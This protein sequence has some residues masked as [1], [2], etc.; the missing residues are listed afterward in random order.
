MF[1]V[2]RKETFKPD[3]SSARSARIRVAEVG[4]SPVSG[5]AGQ[6]AY[7]TALYETREEAEGAVKMHELGGR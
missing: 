3:G 2:D 1:A 4:E 5:Q 6:T 7:S